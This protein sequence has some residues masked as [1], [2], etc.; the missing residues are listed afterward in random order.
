MVQVLIKQTCCFRCL[1][2]SVRSEERK[3]L[4]RCHPAG[5]AG[6]DSLEESVGSEGLR[7]TPIKGGKPQH[8]Q[9]AEEQ[10]PL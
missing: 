10:I 9:V 5:R 6:A 7:G 3:E 1:G 8:P 4:P 2:T